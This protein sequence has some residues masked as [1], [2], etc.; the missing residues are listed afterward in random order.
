MVIARTSTE[1]TCTKSLQKAAS[2]HQVDRNGLTS[3]WCTRMRRWIFSLRR[4]T[5]DMTSRN[6][7]GSDRSSKGPEY[8]CSAFVSSSFGAI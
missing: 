5:V 4:G 2:M 8:F 1:D 7:S 6:C 3:N